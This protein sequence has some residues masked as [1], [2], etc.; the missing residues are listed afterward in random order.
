M[1][2]RKLTQYIKYKAEWKGIQVKQISE[3]NTSKTCHN[4]GEKGNRKTQG[5]FVCENCGLEYNADLNG[6]LNISKRFSDY[7]LENGVVS[8]PAQNSALSREPT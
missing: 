6:A 3:K 4:C 2:Y 1:P 8:E 7:M 5:L